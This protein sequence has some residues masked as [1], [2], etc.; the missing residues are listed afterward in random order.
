MIFIWLQLLAAL[1]VSVVAAW[2]SIIGLTSIF[3]GAVGP[4][5]VMGCVLELAKLATANKLYRTWK[6]TQKFIRSY[7][8]YAAIGLSAITTLGIFGYL[9]RAHIEQSAI[10]SIGSD[11]LSLLDS[12]IDIDSQSIASDR[13]VLRQMD[14]AVTALLG[15]PATVRRAISLRSSQLAERKRL[16]DDITA[17]NKDLLAL[18]TER[19]TKNQ[20]QQR[21]EIDVGPIKYLAQIIYGKDDAQ[22]TD[23]AARLLIGI[24]VTVFDPLAL[25]LLVSANDERRKHHI[26]PI[27]PK[28]TEIPSYR[29]KKERVLVNTEPI[30]TKNTD[31]AVV[32]ESTT[33]PPATRP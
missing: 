16:T 1:A 17:L 14:D 22:T 27:V 24:L 11:E 20:T 9:S 4:I 12:R 10:V 31:A 8:L 33:I 13:Q 2:F 30:R 32:E 23:R 5:I 21:K 28:N 29:Y 25:L 15:N 7:L 6:T 26:D 3:P 18:K 19:A